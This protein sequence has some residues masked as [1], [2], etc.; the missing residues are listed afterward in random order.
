MSTSNLEE[1]LELLKIHPVVPGVSSEFGDRT[2]G[3]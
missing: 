1:L 2:F 3:V